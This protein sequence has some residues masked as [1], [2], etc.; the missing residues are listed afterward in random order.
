MQKKELKRINKEIKKK[1]K[2]YNKCMKNNNPF[3][4]ISLSFDLAVLAMQKTAII[5]AKNLH[6]KNRIGGVVEGC[7]NANKKRT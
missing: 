1:Q 5:C 7:N 6:E 3:G 2:I 4:M